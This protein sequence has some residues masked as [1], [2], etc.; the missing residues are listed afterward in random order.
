MKIGF[1][2]AGLMGAPMVKNLLAAGH[3]VVVSSRKPERLADTGWTVVGSPGEAARDVEIL[4]SIVPDSAEVEQVVRA[5]LDG[6]SEGAVIVEMSTHSPEVARTL[7]AEAAVKGVAYVDAPVSGGPPGADAGTLAIWVGGTDEAVERAQPV[8]DVL[9]APEKIRHCGPVGAGLVV[10]LANNYLGAACAAASAEALAMA[11]EEGLDPQLVIDSVSHGSGA[12]WQLA[13]L[14]PHKVLKGDFEPGF[15]V[16]HM[17]KDVRHARALAGT[18]GVEQPV[19]EVVLGRLQTAME[20][21]GADADYGSV[22]R[23]SGF[24]AAD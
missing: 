3:E 22:A 6:L 2:G 24:D 16:E 17:A 9:G 8:L 19:G 12:N 18:L 1:V 21:Y 10:K 15:K 13:N 4:C 23:L 7:A 20:R 11:R 14:F 5:A